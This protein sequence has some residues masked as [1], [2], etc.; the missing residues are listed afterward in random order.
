MPD[1]SAI[2]QRLES[3][4][5]D[6]LVQRNRVWLERE[7]THLLRSTP[8]KVSVSEALRLWTTRLLNTDVTGQSLDGAESFVKRLKTYTPQRKLEQY[9]LVGPETAGNLFFDLS[10]HHFVGAVIVNRSKSKAQG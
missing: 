9:A 5:S 4:R 1:R 7:D 6:A 10:T 8:A 3:E 2:L